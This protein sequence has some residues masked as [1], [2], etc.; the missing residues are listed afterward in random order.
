MRTVGC[1]PQ[2]TGRGGIVTQ[3]QAGGRRARSA[4][5]WSMYGVPQDHRRRAFGEGDA[6]SV[7]PGVPQGA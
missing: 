6:T 3:T 4:D 7:Q 1:V 2:P 5:G